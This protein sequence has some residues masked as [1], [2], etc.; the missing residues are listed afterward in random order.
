MIPPNQSRIFEAAWSDARARGL[1][2]AE[3]HRF[4]SSE[5]ERIRDEYRRSGRGKP[6]P[7]TPAPDDEQ[8]TEVLCDPAAR[9]GLYEVA[10]WVRSTLAEQVDPGRQPKALRRAVTTTWD[11]ILLNE[12]LTLRG[13]DADPRRELVEKA[14]QL[15]DSTGIDFLAAV[16]RIKESS[17]ELVEKIATYNTMIS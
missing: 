8:L 1:G 13:D 16:E 14:Q 17:P 3:A 9:A 15:A 5:Y 2:A 6:E 12:F 4:A 7:P 11:G 10:P